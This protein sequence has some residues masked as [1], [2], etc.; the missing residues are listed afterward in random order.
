M[1][2]ALEEHFPEGCTWTRPQGG[3]FVWAELPPLDRHARAARRG[4]P[5]ERRVRAGPGFHPDRS[6]H[7]TMRLNFSN[8]TPDR[9]EEGIA[10]LG[11]GDQAA[12]GHESR[13]ARRVRRGVP[14]VPD[15]LSH[16]AP[17]RC[18]ERGGAR[19]G[20]H[21]RPIA[22]EAAS[23]DRRPARAAA[24]SAR[25][26]PRVAPLL[27][28]P[29]PLRWRGG[30]GRSASGARA[31]SSKGRSAPASS[32]SAIFRSIITTATSPLGRFFDLTDRGLG[33]LARSGR[34]ARVDRESIV[35]LDTETTGLS[36]GTGTY[37]FMVGL[38]FF[39]GDRFSCGSSSCAITPRSR[40]CWRR[41]IGMLG[42]HEAVVTFN[43]KSFDVPQLLTRYTANRQRPALRAGI[44]LDL[45]HP[46]RRFWREQPGLVQPGHPRSGRARATSARAT[47]HP[48]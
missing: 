5:G 45:L 15:R 37:V 33:C 2:R 7:N 1:L 22:E 41:S 13:R 48:G 30:T 20:R 42:R 47:C 32:P 25:A 21:T 16:Q 44:H 26:D 36:G 17:R 31:R 3:L 9:I 23:R 12:A 10:R 8:V 24:A 43:G 18:H 40:P 27:P 14:S 39:R 46:S 29:C 34:A 19:S 38:G 28:A 6:G 35:F 4:A 11:P